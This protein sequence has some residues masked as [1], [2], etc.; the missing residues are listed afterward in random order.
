[1]KILWIT[2][3]LFP[4]ISQHLGLSQNSIGGWTYSAAEELKKQDGVNLAVASVYSGETLRSEIIEGITYYLIPCKGSKMKYDSS[5]EES[6]RCI[7]EKFQPDVVHIYGS[8]Y[9]ISLAYVKACG[10]KNVVLSL[11]GIPSKYSRYFY[12]GLSAKSV[13]FHPSLLFQKKRFD[14][15]NN[16]EEELLKSIHYF[17]GRSEWDYSMAWSYNPTLHYY[18]CSR[19]LRPSFY[20]N[21][22]NLSD[23]KR[24]TIFLSQ[25]QYPIKGLH[26]VLKAI[27]YIARQYNDVKVV[28]AGDSP[29]KKDGIHGFIKYMGYGRYIRTLINRLKLQDRVVFVGNQNEK[30]ICDCYQKAHV[31]VC[32]S[33][34]ENVPNSLAEAQML[35][36]P[37]IASYASLVEHGKTGFLYR[38]EEPEVLAKYICDIFASDNLALSF[39]K[40]GRE[41]AIK[42]HN[43]TNNIGTLLD[44][45]R[46][47]IKNV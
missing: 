34:I 5:F 1:M 40:A 31:F 4:S 42:R 15:N 2:N 21:E 44:M 18:H 26:Q 45:Y 37:S 17:E 47:I 25:A 35:G 10:S 12:S 16:N 22:W 29:M 8:E 14:S 43:K 9:P 33:S 7:Y 27:P 28:V 13:L 24:H 19:T 3:V 46:D 41:C 20:E 11:Q 32:P 39:S 36:V 38:F 6:C 23:V 30:Q